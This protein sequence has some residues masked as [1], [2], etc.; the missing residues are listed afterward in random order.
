MKGALTS[1]PVLFIAIDDFEMVNLSRLIDSEHPSLRREMIIVNHH[2]Q[3]GKAKTLAHTHEYMLACVKSLSDRTFIGRM[4]NDG[5]EL[6]P[7]KRSGTAESNFRYGRPNSFYAVLVD[8]QSR[9][10]VG[11]E[12]PP[13]L[14]LMR[15]KTERD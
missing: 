11:L 2:P 7:F 4:S 6:R 8:P 3:G 14:A 1:D 5:V 12:P 9:R 13:T 10:V 15:R